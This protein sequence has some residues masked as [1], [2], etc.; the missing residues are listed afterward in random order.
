MV[1]I[2]QTEIKFHI[3]KTFNPSIFHSHKNNYLKVSHQQSLEKKKMFV[4]AHHF[5]SEF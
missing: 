3:I 5:W 4:M 2:A 1:L